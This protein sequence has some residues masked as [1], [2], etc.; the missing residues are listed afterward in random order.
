MEDAMEKT[1]MD[2]MTMRKT[3][4]PRP[5]LSFAFSLFHRDDE[6]GTISIIE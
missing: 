6:K 1:T 3:S 4:P 2:R 5:S